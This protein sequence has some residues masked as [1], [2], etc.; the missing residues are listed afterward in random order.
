MNGVEGSVDKLRDVA[1]Q[2]ILVNVTGASDFTQIDESLQ[3]L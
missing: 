3:M 1:G 2:E